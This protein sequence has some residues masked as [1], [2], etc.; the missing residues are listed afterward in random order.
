M[1]GYK[2]FR[3]DRNKGRGG[4]LLMY[5]KDDIKCKQI[6]LGS[7]NDMECIVT[8]TLSQQMSFNVIGVYRPPSSDIP[9]YEH[10]KN[11]LKELD[12]KNNVCF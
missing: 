8:I 11:L 9:F 10:F 2:V 7:A 4:G 1:P 5:V 6:D 3:K 12:N